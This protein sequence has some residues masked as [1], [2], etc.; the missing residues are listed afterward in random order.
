MTYTE[1]QVDAA[2]CVWEELLSRISDFK[3]E[4]YTGLEAFKDQN[5]TCTLRQQA[6]G[7]GVWVEQ[8]WLL[9]DEDVRDCYA[10]DWELVPALLDLVE[11]GS[12]SLSHPLPAD[13]AATVNA[14]FKERIAEAER[15][16]KLSEFKRAASQASQHQ[17]ADRGGEW[18]K[19]GRYEALCKEIFE[20][21]DEKLKDMI[22]AV[23]PGY[24][25]SQ[26]PYREA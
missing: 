3:P 13:A 19:A 20:Q 1:D 23:A 12:G 21:G 10:F 18:A 25:I 14:A 26:I 7:L 9:I 15:E 6:V 17:A 16:A 8:A 11:W 22:R 2:L 5:G 4:S 24:L